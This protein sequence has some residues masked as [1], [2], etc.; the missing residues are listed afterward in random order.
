MVKVGI[1]R[2]KQILK[3]AF[4]LRALFEWGDIEFSS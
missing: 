3:L 4:V 1:Q 2:G